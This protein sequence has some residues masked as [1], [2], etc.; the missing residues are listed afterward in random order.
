MDRIVCFGGFGVLV[1]PADMWSSRD[2][3]QWKKLPGRYGPK[4][5]WP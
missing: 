2:G 1:N 3:A 5:R 4:R